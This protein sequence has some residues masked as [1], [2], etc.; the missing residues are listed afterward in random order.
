MKLGRTLKKSVGDSVWFSCW[1]VI[2]ISVGF[3]VSHL[4]RVSV[5]DS[6]R[7]SVMTPLTNKIN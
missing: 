2:L 4:I 5:S 1:G 7:K 6:V 3:S